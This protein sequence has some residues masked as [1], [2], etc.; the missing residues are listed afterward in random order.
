MTRTTSGMHAGQNSGTSSGKNSN[1]CRRSQFDQDCNEGPQSASKN[2]EADEHAA[3]L[4]CKA[5]PRVIHLQSLCAFFA[6]RIVHVQ[7]T[8][9]TTIEVAKDR[10]RRRPLCARVLSLLA[11]AL[12]LPVRAPRACRPVTCLHMH[13]PCRV[14]STC[15]CLPGHYSRRSTCKPIARALLCP[16]GMGV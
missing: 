12:H 8:A 15:T 14:H 4:C 9:C 6:L 13:C 5:T 11:R 7:N 16:L 10:R 3:T 2:T 1:T